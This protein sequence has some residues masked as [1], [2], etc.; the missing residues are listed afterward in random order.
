MRG[1]TLLP[2]EFHESVHVPYLQE[3]LG[4]YL[5]LPVSV[6]PVRQPLDFAL[7]PRR[8]QYHSTRIIE[9]VL[10]M[11]PPDGGKRLALVDRDLFIPILTF[12]FG[13]AQ[14]GGVG[15][16]ISS[17]RLRNEFHGRP[18]DPIAL[19]ERLLKELV[20]ELG[21]TFGLRHCAAA[22]CVMFSSHDLE[23]TDSKEHRFCS[24]CFDRFLAARQVF[25]AE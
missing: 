2:W 6:H 21:H 14:L 3:A 16:V 17:A 13:E 1:I 15:A 10:E 23:D 9:K 12:V 18:A 8:G 4:G 11:D 25:Q 20:H 7:D 19:R 5:L 24:D 22:D